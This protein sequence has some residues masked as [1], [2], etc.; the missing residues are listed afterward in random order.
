MRFSES[1]ILYGLKQ[2]VTGR[3]GDDTPVAGGLLPGTSSTTLSSTQSAD[4]GIK[5]DNI[6]PLSGIVILTSG[7]ALKLSTITNY[8]AVPAVE[9]AATDTSIGYVS[10]LVPRDYDEASDHLTL[11]IAV[12]LAAAD[13][14]I[15][16]TGT[17]NV[18]VPGSVP[19]AKTAVT[20][21]VPFAT[22]L[23]ALG[24]T[25]Q[26]V[27]INLSGYG[28]KRDNVVSV[29]LAYVGTT[30][31]VADIF[32]LHIH[33]DSTIVSYNDTDATDNPSTSG[34]ATAFIQPGFGNPLR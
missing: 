10:F 27:D 3:N 7:T 20:A 30:S 19:S 23:A 4:G 26:I 1:N 15:T 22:T 13:V 29:L 9:T 6:L 21:T 31:G 33:F 24:T 34:V 8:T 12:M 28:L 25:E 17:A 18:T 32:G 16:L 14:G 11:R 2:L 5:K